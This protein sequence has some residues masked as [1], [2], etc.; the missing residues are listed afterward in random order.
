MVKT[1]QNLALQQ[2]LNRDKTPIRIFA[3]LVHHPNDILVLIAT[4]IAQKIASL[5]SPKIKSIILD[6]LRRF[7]QYPTQTRDVDMELCKSRLTRLIEIKST[8]KRDDDPRFWQHEV[9]RAVCRAVINYYYIAKRDPG[10]R[11]YFFRFMQHA[12]KAYG[13]AESKK[14]MEAAKLKMYDF[15]AG[16]T[17]AKTQQYKSTIA[18]RGSQAGERVAY[19]EF[20]KLLKERF[21]Q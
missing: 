9:D 19:V 14:Q 20:L 8:T 3:D 4:C 2:T 5:A 17:L 12:T 10:Y 16:P 21:T 13:F 18:H 6:T 7:E 11:E 15:G 1:K